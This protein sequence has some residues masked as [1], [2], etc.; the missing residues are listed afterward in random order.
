M[1]YIL[2]TLKTT[3]FDSVKKILLIII[4]FLFYS[5]KDTDK[6]NILDKYDKCPN[7]YGLIQFDGCPDSDDDGII[8]KDDDCPE[9]YGLEKFNGCP[10]T[11]SDGIIDKNDDC[12]EEYGLEK[13]NGCPDAGEVELIASKCFKIYRLTNKE[14][15]QYVNQ[16]DLNKNSMITFSMCEIIGDYIY[17]IREINRTYYNERSKITQKTNELKKMKDEGYIINVQTMKIGGVH[18][19]EIFVKKYGESYKLSVLGSRTCPMGTVVF[20]ENNKNVQKVSVRPD[21]SSLSYQVF[22]MKIIQ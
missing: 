5:C 12:P 10:D 9:E 21:P 2:S 14:I 11:D 17:N 20:D 1:Y 15:E 22:Q 16:F 6:D 3:I 13:F 4:F 18:S 8:N 19:Q 7:I